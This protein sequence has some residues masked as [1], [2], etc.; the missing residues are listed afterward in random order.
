V[1]VEPGFANSVIIA[2][3]NGLIASVPLSGPL[4]VKKTALGA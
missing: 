1:N 2:W 4:G 3:N